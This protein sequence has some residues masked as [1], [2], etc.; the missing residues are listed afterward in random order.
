MTMQEIRKT[1]LLAGRALKHLPSERIKPHMTMF[2]GVVLA[3]AESYGYNDGDPLKLYRRERIVRSRGASSEEISA[4]DELLGLVL[5][6]DDDQRKVICARA[7]CLSWRAI[8]KIRHRR[9]ERPYS[10]EGCRQV[11]RGAVV[12]IYKKLNGAI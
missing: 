6:L 5:W 7:M 11:H 8:G 10:H 9:G 12:V 1:L 4:L 3:V 2:P